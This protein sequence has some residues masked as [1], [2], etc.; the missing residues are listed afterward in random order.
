MG[1]LTSHNPIGLHGLLRGQLYFL[2]S[3]ILQYALGPGVHSASNRNDYRKD[4]KKSCLWSKVR[5]VRKAENLI[6]R[7]SRQ[8]WVLNISLSFVHTRLSGLLFRP[9]TSQKTWYSR[10]S[11]PHLWICSQELWPEAVYIRAFFLISPSERLHLN[12]PH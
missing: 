8:C 4:F 1:T 7:L 11:N 10:E 3:F 6:S 9:T 12:A 2:F 5:P